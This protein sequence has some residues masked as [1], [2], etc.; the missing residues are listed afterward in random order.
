MSNR[1]LILFLAIV[2]WLPG[3]LQLDGFLFNPDT[4]ITAYQLDDFEGETEIAVGD[5]YRIE[6]ENIHQFSV[7]S[8]NGHRIYGVYIGDTQQIATDTVF[9]YCHGNAGHIDFYWPRAKLLSHVGGQ[10]RYGVL[11]FDYQG[12]G[13]SEGEPSEEALYADTRAMLQWLRDRGATYTRIAMYGFSMGSAPATKV[14]RDFP[15]DE[16]FLLL[17]APFAAADVFV[18]DATLLSTPGAFLTTL[19]IDVAEH[20]AV[21]GQPFL[22]MHGLAD[23]YIPVDSHGELVFEQSAS[24]YKRAVLV[25][26]AKHGDLPKVMQYPNYINTIAKFLQGKL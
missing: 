13:L 23:D 11:L 6:T 17:E 19:T 2:V 26:K 21:L 5:D 15:G 14:L 1:Q 25:K 24:A 22:W 10:H 20:V 18:Q 7:L 8:S 4:S 9:L 12:Y 16:G 3:C